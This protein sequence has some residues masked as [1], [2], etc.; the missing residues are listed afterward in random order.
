MKVQT[1]VITLISLVAS[2]FFLALYL[3]QLAEK[4]KTEGILA[5]RKLEKS[6]S[7]KKAIQSF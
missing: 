7:F 3:I 5:A 2:I 6:E 4:Q 1:K